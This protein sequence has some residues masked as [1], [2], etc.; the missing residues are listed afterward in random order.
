MSASNLEVLQTWDKQP[1]ETQDYDIDFTEWL[2]RLRD[3]PAASNPVVWT[4]DPGINVLSTSLT[5][6]RAKVWLSGGQDRKRY[7][8]TATM[9]TAGGRIKQ[10]EIRINV[11]EV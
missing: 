5:G 2:D 1:G 6:G 3:T 9:T 8:V 10:A 4:I 11:K 7:R